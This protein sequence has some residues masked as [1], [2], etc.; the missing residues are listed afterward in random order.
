MLVQ[1]TAM[2][3]IVSKECDSR[4]SNV[5][6]N[7]HCSS[8]FGTSDTEKNEDCKFSV[9]DKSVSLKARR[10]KR[11]TTEIK[12]GNNVL[13]VVASGFLTFNDTWTE[14]SHG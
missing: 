7:T 13:H 6:N 12:E 9:R 14:H 1:N 5:E 10:C 3:N 2:L 4:C 8:K 11:I